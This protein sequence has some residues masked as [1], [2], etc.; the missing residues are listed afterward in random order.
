MN[1][2]KWSSKR[3]RGISIPVGKNILFVYCGKCTKPNYF[4]AVFNDISNNF[5]IKSHGQT[6]I[7]YNELIDAV[8][9]LNMAK[10]LKRIISEA[11]F[12][13]VFVV[14][15]KDD[16]LKDNFDNAIESIN[17][18]NKKTNTTFIPLW[19]NQCVELWFILHFEF[20]QQA[21]HWD[22]YYPKLTSY[23]KKKYK[24]NNPKILEDIYSNKGSL[25]NAIK[26]AKKL[27]EIHKDASYSNKWPATNVVAFFENYKDFIN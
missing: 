11:H 23:L 27:L 25:K 14:F 22:D 9:P 7:V 3:K 16:F 4:S 17:K 19:S 15:D 26:N 2:N 24:K 13:E 18:L 6:R 5:F 1:N 10:D 8:D 21:C 20:C 12:D